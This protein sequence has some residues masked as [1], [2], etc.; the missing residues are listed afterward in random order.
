LNGVIFLTAGPDYTLAGYLKPLQLSISHY[1]T[2]IYQIKVSRIDDSPIED[3]RLNS[4]NLFY[5]T[6]LSTTNWT[7]FDVTPNYDN[8]SLFYSIMITNNS[9]RFYRIV[10]KSV[11]G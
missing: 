8:G 7:M 11:S 10:E 6:N 9:T 3:W 5:S 1:F 4:L 2:N